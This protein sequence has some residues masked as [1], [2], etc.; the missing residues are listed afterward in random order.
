MSLRAVIEG[1]ES[2]EKTLTVFDPASPSVVEELE[3][4]FASQ[5]VSVQEGSAAG[6]PGGF[7]VL[8]EDGDVLTA[9]DLQSLTAP[10]R[11]GIG[12]RTGFSKLLEHLDGT[13]FTSY[14]VGQMVAASREIEDRAWRS[15]SGALHAGFQRVRALEAQSDVYAQLGSTTLDVH[16]YA[17]EGGE[18]AE[19]AGVTPHVVDTEEIADSWFVVYDGGD[20]ASDS[21]ALLAEERGN[22]EFYGFWTYDPSIV[23]R[24]LGHLDARYATAP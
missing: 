22:R 3:A 4:Y 10:F 19:I 14:D 13:T 11:R 20:V 6:G 5:R 23:D 1:V 18:S 16:V 21:C 17:A 9:V 7:A 2:R 12:E 8:S 15:K 24:I